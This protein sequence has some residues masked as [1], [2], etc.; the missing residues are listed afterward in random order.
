MQTGIKII[1]FLL[2]NLKTVFVLFFQSSHTISQ[3]QHSSGLRRLLPCQFHIPWLD[4]RKVCGRGNG[5]VT[6]CLFG[7]L[8][9]LKHSYT[10]TSIFLINDTASHC[11]LC[12]TMN[13]SL[14][15]KCEHYVYKYTSICIHILHIGDEII[16][17]HVHFCALKACCCFA[18]FF[19]WQWCCTMCL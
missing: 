2:N 13:W 10:D 5:D 7:F 9:T 11:E 17:H 1:Y 6:V 8:T 3:I 12:C 14:T 16:L 15:F 4:F 18:R 19:V